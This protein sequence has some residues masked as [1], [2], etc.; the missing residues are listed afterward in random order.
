MREDVPL[1]ANAL[2]ERLSRGNPA[3]LSTDAVAA[4]ERYPFPGNVRELENVLERGLSLAADSQRISAA[5]LRLTPIAEANIAS[6]SCTGLPSVKSPLATSARNSSNTLS[7][8][9]NCWPRGE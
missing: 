2:L 5:D 1:I 6:N 3:R 7:T 8:C 9:A 4:L